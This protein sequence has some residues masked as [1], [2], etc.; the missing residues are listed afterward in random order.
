MTLSNHNLLLLSQ[1]AISAKKHLGAIKVSTMIED[2]HYA[3][4]KISHAVLSEDKELQE[5]AEM[6]S[7]NM[8]VGTNLI[9]SAASFIRL[10]ARQSLDNQ[11][12]HKVKYLLVKLVDQLYGVDIDGNAYRN[13]LNAVTRDLNED[14]R[15]KFIKLARAFYRHVKNDLNK[16]FENY[17]SN[18]IDSNLIDQKEKFMELWINAE[19][20]LLHEL[21]LWPL[22]QY[23][24]S[25]QTKGLKGED[26][27]VCERIAKVVL[28]E[29]RNEK[30][31]NEIAYRN[32]LDKIQHL[33]ER[34]DLRGLFFNVTREFYHFWINTKS[35][36]KYDNH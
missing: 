20:E 12:L 18:T 9:P 10:I 31:K 15:E 26:L 32:V 16:P 1:F 3:F 33:F 22:K 21:E 7:C 24:E 29:L 4:E 34:E 28:L 36:S 6:V 19:G 13:A 8:Q 27:S 14:D 23:L 35:N 2:K 5:I 25:I 17:T 30:D 11:S